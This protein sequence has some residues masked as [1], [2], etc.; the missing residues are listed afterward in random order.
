VNPEPP[1]ELHCKV[2]YGGQNALQLLQNRKEL[3]T[4]QIQ[5]CFHN[6]AVWLEST[7][8]PCRLY[9]AEKEMKQGQTLHLYC[10]QSTLADCPYTPVLIEDQTDFSVWNKPS[11]MLS[12]G[13]KWGDHWTIQRWLKHH[14]WPE[15]ECLIT[16][17]LDRFTEGLIIVAH[18][19]SVNRRFHRLFEERAIHKTYRAIVSGEIQADETPV[20][21]TPV[22]G[23][24]ARTVIR[25]LDRQSDPT[26]TLLAIKPESGRKHQIRVH[27]ADSG[28]PVVNDRQYGSPPF[29]GDLMLQASAL[30]FE[31]PGNG[32]A[33]HIELPSEQL[34]TLQKVGS[35]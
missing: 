25:V 19:E 8:K 1:V 30:E 29:S 20:I 34:L 11:G 28:H 32:K 12:Q 21:D 33:M 31:H 2:I 16:H 27:L 26:L 13:S 23:K 3:S 10:N 6:G 14:V 7:G 17:R 15:R 5:Q 18:K 35:K 4:Q 9:D 22:G 24:T